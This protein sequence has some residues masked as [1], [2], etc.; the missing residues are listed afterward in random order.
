MTDMI[1]FFR[2]A[3]KLPS[4]KNF[5]LE[6]YR[7]NFSLNRLVP[8]VDNVRYDVRLSP[9][10][11]KSTV[12]IVRYL[13]ANQT[14]AHKVMEIDIKPSW[15]DLQTEFE[16]HY[17]AVLIGAVNMAKMQ[18]EI[19]IDF[20]AQTA[21]IK[22]IMGEIR[23]Q[24]E[25][26]IQCYIKA[27][28]KIELSSSKNLAS[29]IKLKEQLSDVRS[30]RSLILRNASIEFFQYLAEIPKKQIK[31]LREI[32]FG[33]E[34]S[35]YR[36]IFTNPILHMEDSHDDFF[37]MD[38]YNILL[39]RRFDD[40]DQYNTLVDLLKNIFSD[41]L[42][43]DIQASDEINKELK[44]AI[45]LNE[46]IKQESNI[47]QLLDF[48]NTEAQYKLFKKE[49]RSEEEINNL[50]KKIKQQKTIFAFFYQKFDVKGLIKKIIASNEMRMVAREYCPPLMPQQMVQFLIKPGSRRQIIRQLKRSE[51][52]YGKNFSLK[53]LK[54]QV[55]IW[56][57]TWGKKRQE[58][59]LK[60]LKGFIR[61]HKDFENYM[62]L[63]EAM[64]I[65]NL[66]TDEKIINLSRANNTLFE[67]LMPQETVL[68]EKPIINHVIIKADVRGSTDITH[69]M[70]ERGLN[71]ASYFS[72]NFF[73]PITEILPDYG[74]TKVFIEGDAV[75][76]AITEHE[77]A[78]E[79]WYSV[80]RACGLSMKILSIVKRYN[81]QCRKNQFPILELGIGISYQDSPPAFLFDENNKIM[82]SPAI[83]QADR[84]SGCTKFLKKQLGDSKKPFNLYV[85]QA[86]TENSHADQEKTYMRFN[87][88][89]I[90]LSPAA[91]IK[92]TQEVELRAIEAVFPKIINEKIKIY[93]GK[94]QTV[95]GKFKKLLIREAQI[96][97]FVLENEGKNN[98][99]TLKKYY[100][101]VTNPHLYHDVEKLIS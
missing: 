23:T 35:I 37:L 78:P 75:I 99:E 8:G 3:S 39:G 100:E 64:E 77:K 83:N 19:Q 68:Q 92:L 14:Q 6:H 22:M 82:I 60:F 80:A 47:D 25:H 67:F 43:P 54:K 15:N 79:G 53:P 12:R 55:R 85:F 69:Q 38:E 31:Y 34:I 101:V 45:D 9:E 42:S 5:S 40:P 7:V 70:Q 46:L 97:K 91:F 72:L 89:G 28:R 62:L 52:F 61:Y 84:L 93:L 74:A 21:L 94:F 33:S 96:Q 17:S 59:F 13:L 2:R 29:V 49:L 1:S 48:F 98:P 71:P 30:N 44:P 63:K 10:L 41:L 66:A 16:N 65:V 24:Y 4:I 26:I 76:L 90:E 50:K 56:K 87:V 57:R 20:L 58:I 88:N 81:L 27:I 11:I 51:R 32:N 95:S 86:D 36:D 18:R 73:N